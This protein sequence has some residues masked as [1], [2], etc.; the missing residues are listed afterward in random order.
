MI[1][2]PGVE[3]GLQAQR[4]RL[5]RALEALEEGVTLLRHDSPPDW[6][7]P[8]REAFELARDRVLRAAVEARSRVSGARD[9]TDRAIA[10]LAGRVG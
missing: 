10:T 4:S 1:G 6:R 5:D 9:D 8:A 7:G 3:G 2:I